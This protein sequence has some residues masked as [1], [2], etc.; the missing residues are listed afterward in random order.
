M[1][2][3][4]IVKPVVGESGPDQEFVIQ[5]VGESEDGI[6]FKGTITGTE[7]D[8]VIGDYTVIIDENTEVEGE[9]EEGVTVKVEGTLQDENIVLASKI[10]VEED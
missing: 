3:K 6:E 8:L 4:Y 9:L 7:P 1:P 5:G 10:E 2:I